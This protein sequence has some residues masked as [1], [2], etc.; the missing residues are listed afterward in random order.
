MIQLIHLATGPGWH[1]ATVRL[2]MPENSAVKVCPLLAGSVI[3]FSQVDSAFSIPHEL[4]CLPVKVDAPNAKNLRNNIHGDLTTEITN[5]IRQ[6]VNTYAIGT[7]IEIAEVARLTDM[8]VRTLQ[9]Q[10][11]QRG[12]KFNNLLN[13][14]RFEHAQQMLCDPQISIKDVAKSLGYSDPAHFTRAFRRWSGLSPTAF[15]NNQQNIR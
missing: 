10:L 14:A 4:L 13:Q 5:A 12:L 11:K 15:R 1:P 8:S 9:R 7:Q 2:N 6:I 3:R